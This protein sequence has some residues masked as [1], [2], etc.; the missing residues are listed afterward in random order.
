MATTDA[1]N[2]TPPNVSGASSE[3]PLDASRLV[4]TTT[5]KP[6]PIPAP[7]SAELWAQNACCD[8]MV[9]ARWSAGQGWEA[10]ELKPFGDILISPAA[11]CLHYATQCFEGMKVYRG[12]DGK[13]RLFRPERNAKRLAMSSARVSLPDFDQEELVK[14]IKALVRLDCPRWLPKDKPGNFLYLRPAVIGNGRQIGVQ[15]PSEATIIILMV[16]WPD[17]SS[18]TPPGAPPRQPGLRLRASEH[19]AA[20]AWPGGFGYAKIGANYGPSFLSLGE[21]RKKGHD[22]ILWVLGDKC[23]V[24]EAG[25]SNFFVLIKNASTGRAELITPPLTDK[26]I[27][28][29]IT[30]Q[31]VLDLARSRLSDQ[32]DVVEAD[33]TMYDLKEAWKEGRILEAFVSGTAF[34]ISPVSLISFEAEDW[35]IPLDGTVPAAGCA[36]TIKGWLRDIMFG[37]EDHEWGI[38]VDEE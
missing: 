26:I 21:C 9:I 30:R 6:N 25:S 27:L 23:R 10:P 35:E 16:A 3:R 24:T 17:F 31:S 34:F 28:E 7:G 4:V 8:H 13:L 5:T 12:F 20:R 14:L 33:F 38:V 36:E 15:I 19:G 11:S 22:Q 29:G 1:A 2:G 32:L 18:E 37:K